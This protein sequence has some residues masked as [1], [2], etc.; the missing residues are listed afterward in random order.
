MKTVEQAAKE[1]A[2]RI[3]P[4]EGKDKHSAPYLTAFEH[5]DDVDNAFKAGVEFAQRWISVEEE[6]PPIGELVQ[7][8]CHEMIGKQ[9]IFY[10]FDKI[11]PQEPFNMFEVEQCMVKVTHWKPIEIK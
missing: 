9:T 6:L 7:V 5:N 11:M 3:V 1:Y 8:K 2:D 10:D 4:L